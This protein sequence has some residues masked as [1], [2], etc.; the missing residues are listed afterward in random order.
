MNNLNL[1]AIGNCQI[2]ALL[3]AKARIVWFCSPRLDG[4]PVFSALLSGQDEPE[5]GFYDVIID[6]FAGSEQR[7][8]RNTA[9][10]ETI[11]RDRIGGSV[12]ILDS[13]V[14]DR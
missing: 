8:M 2:S 10:V 3:D 9:I 4:D 14:S 11:L 13:D 7:Y 5:Q 12:R 1:A 6:N